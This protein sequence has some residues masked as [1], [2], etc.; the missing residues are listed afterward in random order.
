M[1]KFLIICASLLCWFI[2][3]AQIDRMHI[4]D[5]ISKEGERLYKSETTS[6]YGTD[7]FLEKFKSETDNIGGYFSYD[8][9][10]NYT[11]LFFSK[12]D[13]P[14]VLGTISFGN[15][16]DSIRATIDDTKR[17]LLLRN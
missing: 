10:G 7:V 14:Q 9:K 17:N 4:A 16:F 11:C 12:G 13:S 15:S 6:W 2:S 8:D 1:K 3:F 5:S